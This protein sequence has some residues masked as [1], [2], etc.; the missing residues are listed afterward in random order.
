MVNIW[1]VGWLLGWQWSDSNQ[2]K[3]C[4]KCWGTFC[5]FRQLGLHQFRSVFKQ[6]NARQIHR[7]SNPNF[8]NQSSATIVDQPVLHSHFWPII[9]NPP[10]VLYQL[11]SNDSK[12]TRPWCA[13][14]AG[15][16]SGASMAWL[17][18]ERSRRQDHAGYPPTT[19]MPW[20]HYHKWLIK[21]MITG[22]T[23]ILRNHHVSITFML[24]FGHTTA[25]NI[26]RWLWNKT[27]KTGSR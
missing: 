9:L 4:Q 2:G 12:W 17:N 20:V 18:S 26:S 3:W 10:L 25:L 7:S 23:P 5:K 1:L 11:I 14:R 24:L 27:I 22:G 6:V 19:S 21:R 8:A 16:C 13:G 15:R